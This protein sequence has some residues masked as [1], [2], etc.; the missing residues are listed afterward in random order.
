MIDE[1]RNDALAYIKYLVSRIHC[2]ICRASYTPNDILAL[3]HNDEEKIWLMT[4]SCPRC[5]TQGLI[6]AIGA[7]DKESNPESPFVELTPEE[8]KWFAARGP[9]SADDVL[10]LHDLLKDHYGD[11]SELL[12]G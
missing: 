10:D 9:I 11:M 3:D 2:P 7:K 12:N 1:E 8:Q 4:I 6:V 5:E